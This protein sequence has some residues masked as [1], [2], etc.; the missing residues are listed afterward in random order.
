[1][2]PRERGK[3]TEEEGGRWKVKNGEAKKMCKKTS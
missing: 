1:M 3:G 2:R